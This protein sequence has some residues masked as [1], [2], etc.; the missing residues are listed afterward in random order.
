MIV[1]RIGII[2][3][4]ANSEHEVSLN[5]ARSAFD[6]LDGEQFEGVLIGID[7][8]GRFHRV[9][10]VDALA[11]AEG[12][13][14]FPDLDDIDVAFPVLHGRFGEDG[15]V[16]GLLELS[17]IPYVGCGVLSSALAMDKLLSQQVLEAAG[18]PTIPTRGITADTRDEAIELSAELEYPL[19][20]KPNR[21]GSSV[22][23]SRVET[24]DELL[25]AIDLALEHDTT[26]LVQMAIV[27]DEIDLGVLQAVNGTLGVGAPLRIRPTHSVFFDYEAKYTAGGAEL[28]VPAQIP[29]ALATQLGEYAQ[30]AFRALD[31]EGLARVDFFVGED[32]TITLNE[33]NTLPGFTA[34]SQYPRM[35]QAV[36]VSYT[37]LLTRLI[38][39]AVA[40]R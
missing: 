5:S 26:A 22:G 11:D 29:D 28:E 1:K 25:A 12:G 15:T 37:E 14:R 20:V 35:W 13:T 8:S 39:R 21:A 36:G 33:V 38:D 9:E 40:I 16:Q 34:F 30:Q 6:N 31:C 4:G 3:G 24:P 19:F 23:A 7:K 18:I 10:T 2:F 27:G 17:G 32:G